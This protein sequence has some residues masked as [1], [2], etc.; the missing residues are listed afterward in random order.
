M[1]RDDAEARRCFERAGASAD[2]DVQAAV[3]EALAELARREITSG[4][5]LRA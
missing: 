1:A 5:L 4:R 2:E 3:A